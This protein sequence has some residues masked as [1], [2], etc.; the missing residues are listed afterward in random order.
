MD[1]SGSQAYNTRKLIARAGNFTDIRKERWARHA[2]RLRKNE[3]IQ[4]SCGKI[5]ETTAQKEEK[6]MTDNTT[7]QNNFAQKEMIFIL[8]AVGIIA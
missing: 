7:A 3:L 5:C 2:T 4:N 6:L 1:R 8:V